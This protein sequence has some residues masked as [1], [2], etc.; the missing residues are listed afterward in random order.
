VGVV[1]PR[2]VFGDAEW[3]FQVDRDAAEKVVVAVPSARAEVTANREFLR[4]VV[5]YAAG[6]GISQFLD[7]G[8]GIPTVGPTHEVAQQV[9][10]QARVAYVDNDPI[11]LA[12]SRALLTTN[13]RT[14][15]VQADV[16]EPDTILHHPAVRELLPRHRHGRDT[17]RGQGLRNGHL[18]AVAPRPRADHRDVRRL[19]GGGTGDRPHPR[20]APG[21]RR[22][23]RGPA[24]GRRRPPYLNHIGTTP[25]PYVSLGARGL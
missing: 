7:I 11:V 6:Q 4:R 16:R 14:F 17:Y 15:T 25:E 23:L 8:T 2:G 5:A 20:L 12:H 19:A 10:P 1:G 18:R 9:N 21:R 24:S 13:D 22:D 3:H